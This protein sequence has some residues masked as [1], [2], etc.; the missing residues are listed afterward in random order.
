MF[1]ILCEWTAV[2]EMMWQH[3]KVA[4]SR[5]INATLT[6]VSTNNPTSKGRLHLKNANCNHVYQKRKRHHVSLCYCRPFYNCVIWGH[7]PSN[8]ATKG[9]PPHIIYLEI[10]QSILNRIKYIFVA[11]HRK[12]STQLKV[13]KQNACKPNSYYRIF[14]QLTLGQQKEP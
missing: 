3:V 1:K 10:F 11:K 6:H 13:E 8:C 2:T 12:Y 14:T 9:Q 7:I 5:G 4:W